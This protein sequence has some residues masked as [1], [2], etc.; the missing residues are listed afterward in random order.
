MRKVGF[1]STAWLREK[2]P[3]CY[4]LTPLFPFSW[5]G[6]VSLPPF[7]LPDGEI[8]TRMVPLKHHVRSLYNVF[9]LPKGSKQ[10]LWLLLSLSNTTLH[11]ALLSHD[12]TIFCF[13]C[14]RLRLLFPSFFGTRVPFSFFYFFPP[15]FVVDGEV[16]F[17]F[18]VHRLPSAAVPVRSC[19]D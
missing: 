16:G 10:R 15:R 3:R 9:F 7:M 11:C 6:L 14:A 1:W 12:Q 4:A 5:A 17:P 2:P 19:Q 13:S 8:T 18:F